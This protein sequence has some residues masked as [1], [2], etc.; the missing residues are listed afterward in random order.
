MHNKTFAFCALCSVVGGF[1]A[2]ASAVTV[3]LATGN[4]GTANGATFNWVDAQSTGSGVID[5]FVRIERANAD[6]VQGFN[7]S[8]RPL[9]FDELTS[10]TFTH[11]LLLGNVPI[12]NGKYEF[13]LDINQTSANPLL[14]LDRIEIYTRSTAVTGINMTGLTD[15]SNLSGLGDLRWSLDS[16]TDGD[17]VVE[18]DYSRNSGSGSGDM[19]MYVP[20][21]FFQGDLGSRSVYLYSH[22]GVP[23]ANNDGYEEW[24]IRLGSSIA[25]PLPSASLMG[26]TGLLGLG[27]MRRR[28]RR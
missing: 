27:A 19:K 10:A 16:G 15:S 12:V 4:S 23:N 24:A 25:A 6:Q 18:L 2:A 26:V 5:P 7:T 3:N 17:S 21:S 1:A 20:V 11:D 13:L 8:A 14:S 28:I 22:F 9:N